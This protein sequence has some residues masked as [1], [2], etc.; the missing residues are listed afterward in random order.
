MLLL[1]INTYGEEVNLKEL[2][3][4]DNLSNELVDDNR[5]TRHQ[6]NGESPLSTLIQ[7]RR[8]T[9][10]KNWDKAAE[11]ID[12]R[13]LPEDVL[14]IGGP[15]LI[16]RLAIVFNQQNV[17][18]LSSV[19][20]DEKGHQNDGLPSYR[21]QLG[22]LKTLAGDDVPI[23]LQRI[24]DG[25]GGRVW[26][27]SNSTLSAV[28]ALWDDYGYPEKI[29]S[30]ASHLPSFSILH[31]ENWQ[32]IG[33]V[34]LV[35]GV[36]GAVYIA[37]WLIALPFRRLSNGPIYIRFITRGLGVFVI[38]KLINAGVMLLGLSL[39]ARVWFASGL[40]DYIALFFIVLGLI[41]IFTSLY[42]QRPHIKKSSA[43]IIRPLATTIKIFV[44]LT[45]ILAW[46]DSAGFNIGTIIAG[47]GIGSL[48]IALAGFRW[49][50][51]WRL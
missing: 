33:F 37:T 42:L 30:I 48:A 47:L 31:M 41:E 11:F 18:N 34:I 7:L 21:D 39:K 24:P 45:I 16:R 4:A 15:E 28:P 40:F 44:G 1:S 20:E 9:I 3:D 8:A 50:H 14:A 32:F 46:L 27:I 2:V 12:L 5:R 6:D 43:A 51:L 49:Q 29:E 19:S 17:I 25:K 10:E 38:F 36:S 23:Y 22:V 26:R 35:I 13:N